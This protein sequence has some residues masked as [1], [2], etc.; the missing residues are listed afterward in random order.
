MFHGS[1]ISFKDYLLFA[2]SFFLSITLHRNCVLSFYVVSLIIY[3][4]YNGRARIFN[5]NWF[6]VV[7][8]SWS[9]SLS[10]SRSSISLS[11][12]P[13]M[14]FY[15]DFII[16]AVPNLSTL[17]S[18]GIISGYCNV[19]YV[20]M[21]PKSV[22]LWRLNRYGML[23]ELNVTISCLVNPLQLN[24]ID[25]TER[26]ERMKYKPHKLAISFAGTSPKN[27]KT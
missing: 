20:C 27:R 25:R 3:D 5:H 22:H 24:S 26:M 1:F 23:T 12:A 16:I 10:L 13:S 21:P 17:I 4:V 18:W 14:H 8:F 7:L 2:C 15:H 6:F 11:L 19:M 9:L